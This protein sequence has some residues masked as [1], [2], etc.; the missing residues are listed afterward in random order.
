[1]PYH[2]K[3]GETCAKWDMHKCDDHAC[4]ISIAPWYIIHFYSGADKRNIIEWIDHQPD[5]GMWQWHKRKWHVHEVNIDAYYRFQV[6]IGYVHRNQDELLNILLFLLHAFRHSLAGL[7]DL[8]LCII[9][10][11]A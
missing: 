6:S 9:F 5:I 10:F 4:C 3:D 11:E 1:M 2:R 8:F 7:A